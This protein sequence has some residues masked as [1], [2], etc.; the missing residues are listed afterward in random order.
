[1]RLTAERTKKVYVPDDSDGGFIVIRNLSMEEIARIEQEHLV[2]TDN[3]VRAN[4]FAERDANYAK[5]CL[6]DW[7][8]MFDENGGE[9]K[10]TARNIERASAYAIRVNEELKRFFEW[11][12]EERE[13]FAEEVKA[14]EEKASKN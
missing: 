4:K 10:F 1:M 5:A 7:G 8:N 9:M 12:N 6:K 14:E 2:V 3:E 13:K 11:V